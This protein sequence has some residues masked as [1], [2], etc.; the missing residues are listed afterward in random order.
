MIGARR[1][2]GIATALL[3]G[4]LALQL[5]ALARWSS[6]S[7]DLLREAFTIGGGAGQSLP[8][9]VLSAAA[10]VRAYRARSVSLSP[11]LQGDAV[12]HQRFS[13]FIYP[14]RIDPGATWLLARAGEAVAPGCATVASAQDL[15]FYRCAHASR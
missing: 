3:L 2:P 13:E 11:S 5:A 1:L 10:H 14:S 7:P 9:R 6:F 8:P 4:L 15:A 12:F